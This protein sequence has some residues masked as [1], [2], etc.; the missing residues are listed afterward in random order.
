[1]NIKYNLYET[2]FEGYV[3]LS[4]DFKI[5]KSNPLVYE[6]LDIN[7][8]DFDEAHSNRL[9][10]DLLKRA[11]LLDDIT[12]SEVT[13]TSLEKEIQTM[14]NQSKW[15][16]VSYFR[17]DNHFHLHFVDI[18]DLKAL[19]FKL[20]Q[21]QGLHSL[22]P[23][24]SGITH[25]FNNKLT[26]IKLNLDILNKEP[27][28]S[29]KGL[30]ALS[31]SSLAVKQASELSKRILLYGKGHTHNPVEVDIN[32]LIQVNIKNLRRLCGDQITF[33]FIP[34]IEN[35]IIFIDPIELDQILLNLSVNA[36]DAM[37]DGGRIILKTM[38]KS[39]SS[40]TFI[41]DILISKG[42]Y[43]VLIFSDSGHGMNK[44][45]VKKIF[46]PYFTT[47]SSGRGT[48]LG[49]ATVLSIVK[50]SK[51]SIFVES[52]L[53]E[54]STFT[55]YFPIL[56]GKELVAK[57]LIPKET[58]SSQFLKQW[59]ILLVEDNKEICNS[60][61]INL[62]QRN[63]IVHTCFSAEEAMGLAHDLEFDLLISDIT[64]PGLSGNFLARFLLELNPNLKIV[65]MS[66]S[67]SDLSM[68]QSQFK[69]LAKPFSM[70]ELVHCIN[71]F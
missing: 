61:K 30:H 27:S 20:S 54:G 53:N 13:P 34:C 17:R 62:E 42:D 29:E 43:G 5:L 60:L 71:N 22:G 66:G 23:L 49:L 41:S 51:G 36:K 50:N 52:E 9:A 45:T 35:P 4:E 58:T 26:V 14:T 25:D 19:Q 44:D 38:I 3:Q 6:L 8:N 63:Q 59:K 67:L 32:E 28:L 55:I 47:K 69:V 33:E 68:S 10:L 57:D 48:G 24:I 7:Q 37:L 64:M 16:R 15:L 56:K 40:D 46:D 12:T 1:M 11:K 70:E 65:L 21:L 2:K 31:N 18:S 39:F